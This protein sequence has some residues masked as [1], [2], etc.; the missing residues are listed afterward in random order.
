MTVVKIYL[1]KS[2]GENRSFPNDQGGHH[3]AASTAA[4]QSSYMASKRPKWCID[5]WW[6]ARARS[7]TV[8]V[9]ERP[10]ES[11]AVPS[12]LRPVWSLPK[13]GTEPK[14]FPRHSTMH[15]SA[16]GLAW[17]NLSSTFI[18]PDQKKKNTK[19]KIH[20]QITLHKSLIAFQFSP[21]SPVVYFEEEFIFTYH[22]PFNPERLKP[23]S[24][25]P[26]SLKFPR[27]MIIALN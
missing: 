15:S 7:L 18:G 25:C 27:F 19:R 13:R 24:N 4:I 2:I 17:S 12:V 10:W 8:T 20:T 21:L 11:D 23:T 3:P 6:S 14:L 26:L 1:T 9:G 16:Q 5:L 22:Q